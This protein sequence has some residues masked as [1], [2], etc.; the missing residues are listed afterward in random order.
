MPRSRADL[1]GGELRLWLECAV[2]FDA[3]LRVGS[4]GLNMRTEMRT[5]GAFD[6]DLMIGVR[7]YRFVRNDKQKSQL[8]RNTGVKYC[9]GLSR[10]DVDVRRSGLRVEPA[11]V[12]G[13]L[14]APYRYC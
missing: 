13:S 8:R 10:L 9:A 1:T 5:K 3:W 7:C 6:V 2:R 4:N 11:C 12:A 14:E